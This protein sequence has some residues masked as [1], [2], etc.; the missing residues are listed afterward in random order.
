M[1][2]KHLRMPTCI[3]C[4]AFTVVVLLVLYGFIEDL[5][6]Q[7]QITRFF[8]S[9]PY[10]TAKDAEAL[11]LRIKELE[12]VSYGFRDSKIKPVA[13]CDYNFWRADRVQQQ[14]DDDQPLP[15]NTKPTEN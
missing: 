4:L 13:T 11:C 1:I 12:S 7:R 6:V 5:R 2:A 14:S 10:L 15:F 3:R 9:G 8:N